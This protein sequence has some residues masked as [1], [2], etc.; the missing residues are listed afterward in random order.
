MVVTVITVRHDLSELDKLKRVSADRY[1]NCL[2][3][4][5]F[6]SLEKKIIWLL[7]LNHSAMLK[8]SD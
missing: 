3:I 4:S 8:V 6:V 5:S 7:S 1:H 2:E